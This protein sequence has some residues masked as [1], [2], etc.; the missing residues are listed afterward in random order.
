M[1]RHILLLSALSSTLLVAC[2]EPFWDAEIEEEI[3]TFQIIEDEALS[4]R[5]SLESDSPA[6]DVDGTIHI[7]DIS[8]DLDEDLQL[9]VFVADPGDSWLD[10]DLERVRIDLPLDEVAA[11]RLLFSPACSGVS[12]CEHDFEVRFELDRELGENEFLSV[13]L[14]GFARAEG[15]LPEGATQA[16][17]AASL[18]FELID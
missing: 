4:L 11:T 2:S 15:D 18:A 5:L 13:D 6:D 16:D 10:G 1:H 17:H 8:Y 14:R 9:S 12:S 3:G 7:E